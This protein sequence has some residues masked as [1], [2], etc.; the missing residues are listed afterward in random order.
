[1]LVRRNG[2]VHE[3]RLVNPKQCEVNKVLK[4][5]WEAGNEVVGF[6]N[7]VHDGDHLAFI[8]YEQDKT[9]YDKDPDELD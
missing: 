3:E 2:Q 1:M 7:V 6:N 5:L 4:A 8:Y 9:V